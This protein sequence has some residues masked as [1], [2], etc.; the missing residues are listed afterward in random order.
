MIKASIYGKYSVRLPCDLDGNVPQNGDTP[1]QFR[2]TSG[3]EWQAGAEWDAF[4]TTCD[5]AIAAVDAIVNP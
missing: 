1:E 2:W 4:V 5:A 3:K